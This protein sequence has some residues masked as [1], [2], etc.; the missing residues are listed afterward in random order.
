MRASVQASSGRQTGQ[1]G[2]IMAEPLLIRARPPKPVAIA[3]LEAAQLPVE[4]LTDQTFEHFL[5]AGSDGAPQG[6]VGL[7]LY[8]S[9]G[10]LRSLV[11]EEHQRGQG[12]GK[13]LVTQAE[14][15]A[16]AQGVSVMYV[17]TNTAEPF[18]KRLGYARADRSLAPP[19]IQH[20]REYSNLCP[21]SAAFMLKKI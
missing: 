15:H 16:Q 21:Q 4:D 6:M 12:L 8:G 17:L 20:T 1:G 19:S 14:A 11:V 18:F 13:A 2:L 7:E 10:L 5:Y 3:M 9:D